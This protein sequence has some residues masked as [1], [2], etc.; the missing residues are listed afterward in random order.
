[1]RFEAERLTGPVGKELQSAHHQVRL[2]RR[3]QVVAE[4]VG[5]HLHAA[6][7]RIGFGILPKVE[8]VEE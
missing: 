7:R 6:Q 2:V 5:R 1:M 4:R 3:D 8:G